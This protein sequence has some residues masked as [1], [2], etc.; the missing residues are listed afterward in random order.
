[1]NALPGAAVTFKPRG[2]EGIEI[3]FIYWDLSLLCKGFGAPCWDVSQHLRVRGR[4]SSSSSESDS[5]FSFST[6]LPLYVFRKIKINMGRFM[7]LTL[8]VKW[9]FVPLPTSGLLQVLR[10]LITMLLICLL[11]PV[12]A[13][14]VL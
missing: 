12:G 2:C 6:Q 5:N 8:F 9:P 3:L 4:Y 13:A 1:M 10:V 14:S 7:P 11:Q